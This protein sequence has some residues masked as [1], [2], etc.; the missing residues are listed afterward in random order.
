MIPINTKVRVGLLFILFFNL[1]LLL[2]YSFATHFFYCFNQVL[3]Y[4][5]KVGTKIVGAKVA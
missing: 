2:K 5:N 1:F 3:H 4:I